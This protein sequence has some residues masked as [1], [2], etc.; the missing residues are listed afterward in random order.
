M[1]TTVAA[2]RGLLDPAGYC[3]A[4]FIL[5]VCG[6]VCL[7]TYVDDRGVIYGLPYCVLAAIGASFFWLRRRHFLCGQVAA[8]APPL[9][10]LLSTPHSSHEWSF[11][12]QLSLVALLA[13]SAIYLLTSRINHRIFLL[14]SEVERRAT[15]DGL[16]GVLNRSSWM[17][18]AE[19]RLFEDQHLGHHTACLFIDMDRF[20]Q[21]NDALGHGAGD[22]ILGQVA[23]VLKQFASTDRLV[24]RIGGDE[25]VVLLPGSNVK[26][27]EAI[28]ERI[29]VALRSV[30]HVAGGPAASIGIACSTGT[31][32]LDQLL[33]RADLAMLYVKDRNRD[34]HRLADA[35]DWPPAQKP[36]IA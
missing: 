31:D 5:V 7:A 27:A 14:S 23:E 3:G 13:S 6:G 22:R 15:Y 4:A 8:F 25:F 16:T 19:R 12:L 35:E 33:R 29:L 26:H 28:A 2:E 11:A 32:T 20:K 21:I 24:G 34:F 10:L 1:A 18:E 36:S 9:V 30:H 17:E